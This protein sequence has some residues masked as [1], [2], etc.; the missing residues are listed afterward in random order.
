[1]TILDTNTRVFQGFTLTT[2]I[3]TNPNGEHGSDCE[4]KFTDG[5]LLWAHIG[6][7]PDD[8]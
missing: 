7:R 3:Y 4:K 1:M 8:R 5:R 6:D 2:R